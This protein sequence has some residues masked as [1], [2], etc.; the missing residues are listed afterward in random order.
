MSDWIS[1][2]AEKKRRKEEKKRLEGEKKR[3]K[4]LAEEARR[5]HHEEEIRA[6]MQRW[7]EHNEVTVT[8]TYQLIETHMNRAKDAGFQVSLS[9]SRDG[10]KL[11]MYYG[12]SRSI[13]IAPNYDDGFEVIFNI[14][15]YYYTSDGA[16]SP[17]EKKKKRNYAFDEI[18]EEKILSWIKWV[19]TG[20][21]PF[22][23]V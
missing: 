10:R 1:R 19:A 14:K 13:D 16:S 20:K 22:W 23:L 9:L 6:A 15:R 7:F 12:E 3:Q 4:Q 21:R 11:S 2:A 17:R 18:P 5:K 8:S